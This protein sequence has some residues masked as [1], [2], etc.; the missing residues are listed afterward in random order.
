M[1]HHHSG[2]LGIN[3]PFTIVLQFLGKHVN[4]RQQVIATAIV[5][6]KRFYTRNAFSWCDPLLVAPTCFYMATKIEEC[7]IPLKLIIREM[8]LVARNFD[9]PQGFPYKT[10]AA[11]ECEFYILEELDCY[12][13][14]Y[15]PYRPL[16]QYMSDAGLK[17]YLQL[18]WLIV[19]DSYRTE[20]CLLYPPYIIALAVIH[21]IYVTY[22]ADIRRDVRQWFA[23]LNVD[24]NEVLEVVASLLEMYRTW[25]DY[26]PLQAHETLAKLA[27][28]RQKGREIKGKDPL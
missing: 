9:L 24:L 22:E 19:N 1:I 14:V 20:L 12:L 6:F 10:E 18:A 27:K 5:Y 13:I 17:S 23:S 7:V 16:I 25:N 26:Q 28:V 3:D 8:D 4:V 15:H 11:I 21:I 2:D